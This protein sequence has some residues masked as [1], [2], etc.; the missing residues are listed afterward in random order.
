MDGT[1]RYDNLVQLIYQENLNDKECRE[2]AQVM[3][4]SGRKENYGKLGEFCVIRDEE[5][6]IKRRQHTTL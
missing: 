3:D 2:D 4:G 5:N 1:Q 6:L